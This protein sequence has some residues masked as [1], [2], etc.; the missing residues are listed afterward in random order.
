MHGLTLQLSNGT[1]ILSV[2]LLGAGL[3]PPDD[4]TNFILFTS[5][6]FPAHQHKRRQASLGKQLSE[7]ASTIQNLSSLSQRGGVK[8]HGAKRVT[9]KDSHA[10]LLCAIRGPCVLYR[11]CSYVKYQESS[12]I[13]TNSPDTAIK[14]ARPEGNAMTHICKEKVSFHLPLYGHI[15][16]E[17]STAQP[18]SSHLWRP[19]LRW[20]E[21]GRGGGPAHPAWQG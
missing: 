15:C 4:I 16:T 7:A 11:Q 12:L 3:N 5:T 20:G 14:H 21:G 1:D 9:V 6:N 13:Y 17:Q 18:T 19:P 8:L 10:H 2:F